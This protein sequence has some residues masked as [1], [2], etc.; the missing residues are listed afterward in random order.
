MYIVYP[1]KYGCKRF[2]HLLLIQIDVSTINMPEI[3]V[4]LVLK[5]LYIIKDSNKKLLL[6]TGGKFTK[7][8]TC[9]QAKNIAYKTGKWLKTKYFAN[10]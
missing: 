4:P 3:K 8:L 2:S 7:L 1:F 5:S 10:F 6:C 9:S